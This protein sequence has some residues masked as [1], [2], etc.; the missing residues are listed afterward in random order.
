MIFLF[1]FFCMQYETGTLCPRRLLVCQAWIR[2]KT[3]LAARSWSL[4]WQMNFYSSK[5]YVL[6][7]NELKNP[8]IQQFSMLNQ[9]LLSG[10]PPG[11]LRGHHYWNTE[12]ENTHLKC[13]EQSNKALGFIKMNLHSCPAERIKA[14]A[15]ISL[16]R[17]TLECA[18][19]SWDPY[20]KYQ[21]DLPEQVQWRATRFVTRSYSREEGRVTLSIEPSQLAIITILETDNRVMH[22]F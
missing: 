1:F 7:I 16:V 4:T 9:A 19:I 12:L 8:I 2:L 5:C 15:Y 13:K 18:C 17:P 14:Q 10:L 21:I 11:I 3:Y 22:S 6:R 20:R